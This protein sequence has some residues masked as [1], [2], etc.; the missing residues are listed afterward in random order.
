MIVNFL[1]T[2]L[3][4]IFDYGSLEQGGYWQLLEQLNWKIGG[5]FIIYALSNVV[6][7]LIGYLFLA[8]G[9][10]KM[11]RNRNMKQSYFAWIPFG[12]LYLIGLLISSAEIFKIKAKYLRWIVTVISLVWFAL[13]LLTDIIALPALIQIWLEDFSPVGYIF[14]EEAMQS[15]PVA[16]N[17]VSFITSIFELLTTIGWWVLLFVLFNSYAPK[18]AFFFTILSVLINPLGCILVFV[19]RNNS[20]VETREFMKMKMHSMYGGGNPYDYGDDTYRDP[21]DLSGGGNKK[22]TP[23]ESPFDEYK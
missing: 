9:L 16:L 21:Y 15:L 19:V 5:M 13:A 17:A 8:F 18:S 7:W 23:P 14:Y 1:Q 11:A 22:E 3:Y 2:F 10:F 6:V 12:Q 4:A 20:C